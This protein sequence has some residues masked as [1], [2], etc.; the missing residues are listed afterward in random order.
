MLDGYRVFLKRLGN[1]GGAP[2]FEFIGGPAALCMEV[3]G[4]V[5]DTYVL[6]GE[7]LDGMDLSVHRQESS[8]GAKAKRRGVKRFD[9]EHSYKCDTMY[10]QYSIILPTYI[11][12][13][14]FTASHP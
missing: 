5:G 9:V 7:E 14:Y 4:L 13:A 10:L 6:E 3:L 8:V 1:R 12:F 11:S 2:C